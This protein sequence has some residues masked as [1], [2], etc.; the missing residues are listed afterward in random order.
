MNGVDGV[1]SNGRQ[2]Q[3]V[4]ACFGYSGRLGDGIYEL[5]VA[6]DQSIP[7]CRAA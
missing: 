4:Y 7:S 6:A 5:E 2:E 1:D 3:H